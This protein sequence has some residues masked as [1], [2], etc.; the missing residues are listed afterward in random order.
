MRTWVFRLLVGLPLASSFLLGCKP[1][2]HRRQADRAAAAIIEQKQLEALGRKEPFTTEPASQT[3]RRRILLAGGLPHSGPASLGTDRLE[4]ID[5]WPEKAQPPAVEDSNS[6]IPPWNAREPLQFTLDEALQV[7]A[8]NNRSYQS[9]KERIFQAALDLDLERDEFRNTFAGT[10]DSIYSADLTADPTETGIEN[11]GELA[12]S[13]RLKSGAALSGRI[14]VDLVNLLTLD[15]AS[16]FGI[17]ADATISIPLLRGSG[18]HIVSEPLTQDQ[19]NVVYEIH[20]FERFKRTLAVSVASGY[21]SV[22]QQEDRRDNAQNNYRSLV[23]GA[24]RAR[25]MADA[26][27]LSEIQVDQARQNE[28]R[29]RDGWIA[30]KQSYA[31]SLDV[32]KTTLGLPTDANIELDRKSLELLA[33]AAEEALAS[34]SAQPTAGP[35]ASQVVVPADAEVELREPTREGAGPLEM[36]YAEAIRLALEKRLDLRT[37]L[38]RVHDAQRDVVVAADDLRADLTLAASADIG[39]RRSLSSVDSP[40]ARLRPERGFYS[41]GLLLDLPLER[42]AERNAYRNSFIL[43]EQAVRSVQDLEDQIKLEIRDALRNLLQ[44]RES[45]KI[46]AQAVQVATR[47]VASTELF[48]AAGD[49]RAQIRDVLEAQEDLVDAQNDFTA[50]LVEYRVVELELQRDMGLLEVNE[51][52]LWREY[53]PEDHE[54]K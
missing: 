48:L 15:Q 11:S 1:G 10:V 8:R 46:Q 5:H 2:D 51:K 53:K 6:A 31:R 28:L 21:L 40:N 35:S 30:A 42:T 49:V 43:L 33:Q 17:F 44:A 25:R 16:A 36:D 29:A 22:L 54:S 18:K 26:G 3:L 4:P 47:R 23:I 38:G 41:A 20:S 52:G 39:D 34:S 7:A 32:F 37:A 13:R 9:Q 19:R 12:L 14:A 24:R 45:I 27:R 50:A